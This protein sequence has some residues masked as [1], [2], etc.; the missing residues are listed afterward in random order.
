M[1]TNQRLSIHFDPIRAHRSFGVPDR[2]EFVPN[3]KANYVNIFDLAT[4]R[5]TKRITIGRQPDVSA[6]TADGR[7][8]YVASA[9]NLAVVDLASLEVVR[10]LF[11]DGIQHNYALNVF[12]DGERM[13]LYNADG[14]IVVLHHADAPDLLGVERVIRINEPALPDSAVGGKG[15][16]TADG[17]LYVNANWHADS[18]FA[19]DLAHDY[20]VTSLV[21][22]EVSRPDDLVMTADDRYAYVASYGRDDFVG[23]V[24][25]IDVPER[26]VVSTIPV[27]RHPAGLTMSPD[28]RT[29]YVTNVPD[30][31][32]SAIDTA[33]KE[34]Q[35]TASAAGCYREAG[36]AGD[37]L[38]IEG[39]SVSA[40]GRTLY[41]YAVSF[42]ALVVFDDLGGANLPS[43]IPGEPS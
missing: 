21:T 31:S 17:R 5:C 3:G 16:F 39:V 28:S 24:H 2:Y 27:G 13:F 29:V 15:H 38:D 4:R 6:T 19:I 10:T 9:E 1:T 23:A 43:F 33:T 32:I 14:S 12:P 41:A 18:V 26:R 35:Y 8:L 37:H 36:I 11:G 22:T 34:V 7:F 30:G 42:G 40:D 25:V 20:A